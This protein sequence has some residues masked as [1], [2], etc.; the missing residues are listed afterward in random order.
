MAIID[1]DSHLRDG[2]FLDEIYELDGPFAAET[3][4]RGRITSLR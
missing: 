4:K 3:P 2:W 1:L